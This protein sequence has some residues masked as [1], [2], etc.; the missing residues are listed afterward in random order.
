MIIAWRHRVAGELRA[1]LAVMKQ[2]PNRAED[3]RLSLFQETEERHPHSVR[4]TLW[5]YPMMDLLRHEPDCA[6]NGDLKPR[7]DLFCSARPEA[8]ALIVQYQIKSFLK[9]LPWPFWA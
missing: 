9:L 7:R 2:K 3:R 4:R 1:T 5:T 6:G 8:A